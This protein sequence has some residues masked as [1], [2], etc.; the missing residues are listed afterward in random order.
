M[1]GQYQ[2]PHGFSYTGIFSAYSGLT[3]NPLAGADLNGDTVTNDRPGLLGRNSFRI[4]YLVNFDS[5]VA[6]SFHLK[7]ENMVQLRVDIFNMF[8]RENVTGVNNTYGKNPATPLATFLTPTKVLNPR[9]FQ[10]SARYTF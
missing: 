7:G 8:N 6:K 10:F 1:N 9:E 5:A 3:V 4:P 2:F